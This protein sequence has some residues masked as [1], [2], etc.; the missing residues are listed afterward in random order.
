MADEQGNAV[1][2]EQGGVIYSENSVE[3]YDTFKGTKFGAARAVADRLGNEIDETYATKDT[4][5][6]S[7]DGLMSAA[8][9]TKLDGITDYVVSASVSGGTLTL[10]PKNG[11]AVTFTGDTNVIEGV[12]VGND[13]LVP[14]VNKVVTVP[15]F[16]GTHNGA[17]NAPA[18]ANRNSASFLSGMGDWSMLEEVSESDIDGMFL[19]VTIGGREYKVVQIGNQLWMAENLD[20]KWDG[21]PIGVNDRSSDEQRA[22][23]YNNDEVTYGVNGNK[24]GLLYNL[25]AINYLESNKNTMLP[26]GW[27]VPTISDFNTLFTSI[28]SNGGTKLKST[29]GWTSG[30]GTDDYGF[31]AFPTG[32]YQYGSF[33]D[34]GTYT[35]FSSSETAPATYYPRGYYCNTDS[36]VGTIAYAPEFRVSIRLVK[37]LTY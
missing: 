30:N 29:T 12:K 4:A 7:S 34:V 5:T 32:Y 25:P 35:C 11:E 19:S 31:S 28:G 18:S 10:T 27:H 36:R 33:I 8:D 14:D 23:Y 22:S 6:T 13:T 15:L 37:N 17:V 24:Y 26:N 20:W 1:T 16:D 9:K 2:D 3:L 21:L